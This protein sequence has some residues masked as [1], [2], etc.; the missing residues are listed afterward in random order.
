MLD[1]KSDQKMKKHEKEQIEEFFKD[2]FQADKAE[3]LPTTEGF[4][5]KGVIEV[6]QANG[7]KILFGLLEKEEKKIITLEDHK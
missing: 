2:V 3:M 6:S 1:E 5:V 7:D 4:V